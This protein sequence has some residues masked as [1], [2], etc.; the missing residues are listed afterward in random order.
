MH[1]RPEIVDWFTVRVR[2]GSIRIPITKSGDDMWA[3][4]GDRRVPIALELQLREVDAPAVDIT[5]EVISHVPRVTGLHIWQYGDGREVRKR[6]LNLDLESL[7]EQAIAVVSTPIADD[8]AVSRFPGALGGDARDV[9]LIR[10]GVG[11]VRNARKRSQR[12]MTPARMR[13]IAEIYAANE[14]GGLEA[15]ADAFGVHRTTAYRWLTKVR[16]AGMLPTTGED[17]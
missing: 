10:E 3:Q 11:A 4:V 2:G 15:V 13:Q 12:V 16:E 14:T 5:I 1:K 8:S 7:V 9:A 17:H 6:D